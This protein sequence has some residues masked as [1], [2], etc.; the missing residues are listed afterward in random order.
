MSWRAEQARQFF[1][2]AL[3]N[4]KMDPDRMLRFVL[5]EGVAEYFEALGDIERAVAISSYVIGHPSAWQE[6]KDLASELVARSASRLPSSL[7]VGAQAAYQ[8]A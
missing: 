5:L 6:M 2:Q 7:L 1:V 3:G 8:E 4:L